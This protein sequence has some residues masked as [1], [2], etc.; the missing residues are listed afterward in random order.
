[1]K[2][3]ARQKFLGEER[4]YDKQFRAVLLRDIPWFHKL[5]AK[6]KDPKWL[7][8]SQTLGTVIKKI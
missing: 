2:H 6:Y 1:M 3:E 4:E 8:I 5:F 7:G